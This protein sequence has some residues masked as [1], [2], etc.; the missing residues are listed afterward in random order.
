[1]TKNI[2]GGEGIE[3]KRVR[4]GNRDIINRANRWM[5]Q[6]GRGLGGRSIRD[7]TGMA[8]D[9]ADIAIDSSGI[10][11]IDSVIGGD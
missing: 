3:E 10:Y 2:S 6:R 11:G 7:R 9:R 4:G 5:Q 1:M 8:G